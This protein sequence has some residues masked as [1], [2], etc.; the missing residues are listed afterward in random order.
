MDA[1]FDPANSSGLFCDQ[2][3]R[4][5]NSY[6]VNEVRAFNINRGVAR[7]T[8]FDTQL[9]FTMELPA[10]LE[11]GD[12]SADLNINF[13]WTHVL[14]LSGQSTPFST[15]LDCV[16]TF[17]WPCDDLIDGITWPKDRMLSK[18]TY[19]SGDFAA[20]LPWRWTGKSDN[21]VF[22]GAPL[23]Y[24]IPASDLD[25]EITDV[26]AKGYFDASFSYVFGEHLI[27]L[28]TIA[29][30][31]DNDP[32]MMADWVKNKNTDTRLYDIFGRS[33]TL[34]LSMRF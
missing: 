13:I 3:S 9:T 28:L 11:I 25:P 27:A 31:S 18:F 2:I 23:F 21:G 7:T 17:G 20:N 24:G 4:D 22:V 34:S 32:P 5:S 30:L 1:C 19:A 8:G 26:G 12:S 29:N 16:G 6:N 14:E 10:S 15:V 33:Y